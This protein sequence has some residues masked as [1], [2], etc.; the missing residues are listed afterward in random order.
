MKVIVYYINS[1]FISDIKLVKLGYCSS[2]PDDLET[3]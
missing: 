3:R 1:Y 2:K